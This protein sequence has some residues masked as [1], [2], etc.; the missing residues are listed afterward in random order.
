MATYGHTAHHVELADE[1]NAVA[2]KVGIDG[3]ADTASLN[4]KVSGVT[5]S[6]KAVS[7]TGAETLTN[8]TLTSPTLNT[9]T[10]STG[11]VGGA[12][13]STSAITLGYASTSTNQT[14]ISTVADLTSLSTTVTVPSGSRRMK[15]TGYVP[16]IQQ[17]GSGGVKVFIYESSTQL[18]AWIFDAAASNGNVGQPVYISTPSAGSH[19]YKLRMSTSANTVNTS[20]DTDQLAF[21]LVELI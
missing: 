5:G 2:T 9:P 1:L 12:D 14:G 16:F 11:A 4:Y 3:S 15:I 20:V 21:I 19:T 6:D 7:K 17:T 18:A 10:F 13:L 8:K